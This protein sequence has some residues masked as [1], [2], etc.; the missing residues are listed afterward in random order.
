MLHWHL[1]DRVLHLDARA[2]VMGIVN[3]TPDSFSGD[4]LARGGTDGDADIAAAVA[5]ARAF[6]AAGADMIDV[7]GESTRP[8]HEPVDE[9]TELARVVPAVRAIAAAVP[10]P[11]SIDTYKAAVAASALEAGARVIN[12]VWALAA[13]PRMPEVA[14]SADVPVILMHNQHGTE[15]RDLVPDIIAA[16]AARVRAAEEA[17]IA[18]S[19][20][21]LDPGIGFG[22][23]AEHNLEFIDRL[24][25][26]TALGL[27]ILLGPSRKRFIGGILDAAPP[28]QRLEGTAAAVA[29]G[30][31]RGAD[32]VRAH[33]V[34]AMVKVA[35]VA[36]AITR[37]ASRQG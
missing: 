29:I 16:L 18:R 19:R 6:V 31:A 14:A 13:D 37:R 32:I 2:L 8:G 23:T 21:I 3:V 24:D 15:Y 36:D 22:M 30:I 28:E 34:A 33:D 10:V 25:E 20:L 5:Q 26:L 11:V 12:D 1:P 9:A 4:G 17:G 35:R 7:G 27:P